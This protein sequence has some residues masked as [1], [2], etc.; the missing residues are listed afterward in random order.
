MGCIHDKG[1]I[2]CWCLMSYRH[3]LYMPRFNE[4][5]L[6]KSLFFDG[7]MS[8]GHL[9]DDS[10]GWVLYCHHCHQEASPTLT[11]QPL[12][13][14]QPFAV[15][16][17]CG[18]FMGSGEQGPHDMPWQ[19]GSVTSVEIA[20]SYPSWSQKDPQERNW[21]KHWSRV[22]QGEAGWSRHVSLRQDKSPKACQKLC[23]N[24]C[25]HKC[26][27]VEQFVI[28]WAIQGQENSGALYLYLGVS[29][30]TSHHWALALAA[31]V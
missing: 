23:Q 26:H 24:K 10:S 20:R 27:E 2:C 28:S 3:T 25:W 9:F 31:L 30:L 19:A 13:H 12:E 14:L 21:S 17:S 18:C 11:L 15:N 5:K 16:R 1:P 4:V 8:P 6:C 22:K 29:C 7:Y